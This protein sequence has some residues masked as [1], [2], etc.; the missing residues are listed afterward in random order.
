MKATQEHRRPALE[1]SLASKVPSKPLIN[2]HLK[3][4]LEIPTVKDRD[5][6]PHRLPS[7]ATKTDGGPGLTELQYDP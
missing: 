6:F 5:Q 3:T 7:T 2:T 4:T 1:P